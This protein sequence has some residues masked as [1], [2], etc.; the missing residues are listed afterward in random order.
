M[1]ISH[2][3]PARYADGINMH[4]TVLL[5][6]CDEQYRDGQTMVPGWRCICSEVVIAMVLAITV[7]VSVTMHL[8]CTVKFLDINACTC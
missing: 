2:D 3:V 5:P 4:E 8:A 1:C 7:I 6:I